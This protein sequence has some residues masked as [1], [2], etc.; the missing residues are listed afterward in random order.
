MNINKLFKKEKHTPV[1]CTYEELKC[2]YDIKYRLENMLALISE[3]HDF[4][5]KRMLVE[6][7]EHLIGSQNE[8]K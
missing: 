4:S 7:L 1:W 6:M 3:T 5:G 2:R 8:D